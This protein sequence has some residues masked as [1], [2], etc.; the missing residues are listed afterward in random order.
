[1]KPARLIVLAIAVVAGG[2]AFMMMR[3]SRAPEPAMTEASAQIETV[4]VLVAN[5]DIP[6][7]RS[8]SAEDI[9]WKSWPKGS[10]SG[11]IVTRESAPDALTKTVGGMAR[12]TMVEGEPIRMSKIV[13]GDGKGFLATVI[14]PGMRAFAIPVAEAGGAGGFILPNDYVD[15]ILTRPVP[16]TRQTLQLGMTH[17]SSTVLR[18]VRVLAID[19]NAD[20]RGRDRSL[21]AKTATLE[22]TPE[23]SETLAL[24]RALGTLSLTLIGLADAKE[25]ATESGELMRTAHEEN[26]L[27]VYKFGSNRS[28]GVS[29]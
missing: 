22:L 16:Q 15:V 14:H 18:N 28:T 10:I 5:R 1:M 26:R 25:N 29:P 6:L 27:N 3:R 2:L 13:F 12:V 11:Q 21:L 7:G 17:Q 9:S 20:D 23:Q 24:S 19:Q 8:L 4:D